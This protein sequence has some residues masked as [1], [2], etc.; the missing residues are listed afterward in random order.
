MMRLGILPAVAAA[1]WI[2]LWVRSWGELIAALVVSG[3]ANGVI[4][5]AANRYVSRTVGEGRLGFAFGV[6]QAAIPAATPLS[7]W[8]GAAVLLLLA[9]TIILV[10]RRALYA[11]DVVP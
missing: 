3:V 6:K 4:Q 1:V 8:V 11:A 7:A 5:P 9:A 10:G 2:G